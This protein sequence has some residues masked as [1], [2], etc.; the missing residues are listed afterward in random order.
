MKS[1]ITAAL[2]AAV[3]ALN[4]P[5]FAQNPPS[6][7]PAPQSAAPAPARRAKVAV[8]HLS[9]TLLERPASFSLSLASLTGADQSPPLSSLIVTL[10]KAAKD[11]TLNGVFLDLSAFSLTLN[12][13]QEI[14]ALLTTL[15]HN[16]KRVAVYS[17]DYDLDTY[18]LASYADTVIMPEN[19]S[20]IIPGVG[21]QMIFFKGALDKLNLSADFV[22]VG[23]FKGAEEPFTRT[24]PSPE[25]K[26]QIDKLV[27]GMYSEVLSIIAKNRPNLDEDQVKKDIDESWFTGTTAKAAGLIDQTMPRDH[28]DAWVQS[29]FPAGA[30][31]VSDYGQPPKQSLDL[32]NPFALFSMLA[33]PGP[34]KPRGPEIAVIYAV[35][36]IA[37][38]S[39]G[40]L[41][42]SDS[43]T[44]AS[45]REAVDAA[46]KDDQVKAI[47]LRID[48]PGGSASASDEIWAALKDADKKKPVTVSMG[49]LAAS[50]GYYIAC[51]GRH[52]TADPATITGSI[53]VVGGKIVIK[54]L[55]D[56]VGI[57]IVPVSRGAHA[58]MLSMLQPFTPE[59]RAF[60]Q[61]TM[62]DTYAV[63]TSR[64]T[65]ARGDKIKDITAVAQGRLFTGEQAIQAGLVD[66][67]GTL[68]D[69]IAAAAKNA[70]LGSNYQI[71][72]LP[73][74]KSLLDILRE[75]FSADASTPLGLK[76]DAFQA[77]LTS[78]PPEL[79]APTQSALH[80]L[81]QLQHEQVLLAMPPGLVESTPGSSR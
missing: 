29:Q 65:A 49:R 56:K 51:A 41:D 42:T 43:V 2:T 21:L 75:G 53:G 18:V 76:F 54:D 23:K 58:D 47:V 1:C 79:R 8:I 25:Y 31:L 73:E 48:S 71:L 61:K 19:G 50:G 66:D 55:L 34:S 33:S 44:P 6:T 4:F 72:V 7:A 15:R 52:I 68:N 38:D 59:E 3:L 35:G 17:S 13:A 40:S 24:S 78:L 57:S 5:A 77:A 45:I 60:V 39:P 26:A 22:Q 14:G 9:D 69:T 64:V 12:Q 74:S 63:F 32:N 67:V 11:A 62:T 36:E 16:G 28:V 70:H 37:E 30:T 10:N 81:R 46:L 27:D 20:V 80:M